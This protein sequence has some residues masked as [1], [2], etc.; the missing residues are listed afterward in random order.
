LNGDLLGFKF[1]AWEG[2]HRVPMIALWPGHVEAGSTSDQLI[3]NVDL[4]ATFAALTGQ[5]LPSDAA[6]D[7][8]N[9][10]P[11]LV[12]KPEQ[13]L[14][15]ELVLMPSRRNIFALRSGDWIYINA[16]GGGGF[17]Q[18]TPGDHALGGPAALLF[19]GEVNS[20]I[21]NGQFKPNAPAQQLYNLATDLREATNL[22]AQ[23]PEMVEKLAARLREI[24]ATPRTR[25]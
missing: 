24:Q 18:T 4:L 12:G 9:V 2:G 10:L 21:A 14:R 15:K 16:Q 5:E 6:P 22:A 8:L 25:P 23:R 17:K 3:C 20:D 13:P 1:D 7:S 19:A 11:A